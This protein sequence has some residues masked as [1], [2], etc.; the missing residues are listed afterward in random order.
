MT[1]SNKALSPKRH[2]LKWYQ[3]FARK[4]QLH[5]FML[6]PIVW[7]FIFAYVPMAGIQI[8][9]KD[10]ALKKGVWASPWSDPWYK[11]FENFFTSFMFW[12]CV[13]NTVII[14]LYSFLVGF[15]IPII[16]ALIMNVSRNLRFRKVVQTVTYLPHFISMVVLVGMIVQMFNPVTGLY[17]ALWK[18]FGG[19]GYPTSPTS[20]AK[21]FP[22][23]Y[24]WS[25]VWQ[26]FGWSSIIYM[27]ALSGVPMELHE[28]AMVDGAT[29]LRRVLMVDLPAIMPT[30][31]ILLIMNI[32]HLL[33]V[34]FEKAYLLQNNMNLE[35]SEVIATHVY[36]MTFQGT[37][38][39][40]YSYSTAVG[41]VNSLFNGILLII[42]NFV[43]KRMSEDH[44]SLF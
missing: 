44:T 2:H 35:Y 29:R 37:S 31:E 15:P 43:T 40:R 21:A 22:H 30:I 42:A 10:F 18:F 27:A 9:F 4:W 5:L 33:G 41:L 38:S 28:A 12:R 8:A 34:G 6:I 20:V 32:G 3:V 13:K 25:G 16:F 11:H 7:I 26:G 24:V 14:S 17:G 36:K 23:L 1:A 39:T 19:S